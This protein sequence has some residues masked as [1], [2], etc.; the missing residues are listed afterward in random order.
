MPPSLPSSD[1]PGWSEQAAR[2]A[3]HPGGGLPAPESAPPRAG[4][5][6]VT[7]HGY[8]NGLERGC[9]FLVTNPKNEETQDTSCGHL[10]ELNHIV[11]DPHP[12]HKRAGPWGGSH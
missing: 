7:S 5:L 12:V 9:G 2:R 1:A 8:R 6:K 4:G 10:R 11:R 3:P